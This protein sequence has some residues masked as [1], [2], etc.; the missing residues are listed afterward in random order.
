MKPNILLFVMLLLF[1]ACGSD[2]DKVYYEIDPNNRTVV[3]EQVE[4]AY[5]YTYLKVN[6]NRQTFWMAVS[7][8]EIETGK[9]LHFTQAMEMTHFFSKELN[10][11]FDKIL[12]VSDVSNRPIPLRQE[13]RHQAAEHAA[14][15]HA[16]SS[17]KPKEVSVQAQEGSISIA[18]LYANKEAYNNKRVS[19]TG[20]VTRYNPGIMNRNW[21]H[22][23][24]GTAEGNQ[25]DLT[26]TS[27]DEVAVGDQILVEGILMLEKDFGAGYFYDL[28]V[29]EAELSRIVSR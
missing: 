21:I 27:Q 16:R 7:E 8:M 23:Q 20:E 18:E 1:T 13:T 26:V 28:I 15:E 10:R 3:V 19:V 5:P 24:D 12:F 17:G 29:E 6:E 25:F 4:Q 14:H 22:I 2:S 9:K 11:T